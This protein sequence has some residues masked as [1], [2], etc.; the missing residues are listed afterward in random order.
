MELVAKNRPDSPPLRT[1][2]IKDVLYALVIIAAAGCDQS[3]AK[4]GAGSTLRSAVYRRDKACRAST[5]WA[6]E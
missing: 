4:P 6:S 5:R 3:R 1:G 2:L